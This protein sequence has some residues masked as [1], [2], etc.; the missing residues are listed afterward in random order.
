MSLVTPSSWLPRDA[1]DDDEVDGQVQPPPSDN[2]ELRVTI[3]PVTGLIDIRGKL[4]GRHTGTGIATSVL[5]VAPIAT[6]WVGSMSGTPSWVYLT[7]ILAQILAS[8]AIVRLL[9]RRPR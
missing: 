4:S 9:R 1:G 7:V 2:A 6:L 5:A 8:V 3:E